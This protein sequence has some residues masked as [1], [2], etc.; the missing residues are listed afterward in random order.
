MKNKAREGSY[1]HL[2]I[3]LRESIWKVGPWDDIHPLLSFYLSIIR[4]SPPNN[5]PPA[6]T[7]PR[8]I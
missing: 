1:H 6:Q 3:V 7:M 5:R 2:I 8:R 4:N